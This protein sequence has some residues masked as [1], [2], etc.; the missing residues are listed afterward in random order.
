MRTNSKTN[1]TQ[2]PNLI[3]SNIQMFIIPNHDNN[4][5]MLLK[6]KYVYIYDIYVVVI[7]VAIVTQNMMPDAVW[8]EDLEETTNRKLSTSFVVSKCVLYKQ[9]Y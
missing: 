9:T 6:Y 2:F 8:E 5:I 7:V 4:P 3:I 1:I